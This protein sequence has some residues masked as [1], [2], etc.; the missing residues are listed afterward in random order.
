MVD[1]LATSTST[2]NVPT[3]PI[4][5]YEIEVRNKIFVLDSVK[6]WQVFKDD[7]QIY[8]FL[9]LAG[10]FEGETI[11]EEN[12]FQEEVSPTQDPFENQIVDLKEVIQEQESIAIDDTKEDDEERVQGSEV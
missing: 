7:K 12:K 6:R 5:K 4:G 10:D 9:T 1:S 2:F 3:H 8:Q 11:D